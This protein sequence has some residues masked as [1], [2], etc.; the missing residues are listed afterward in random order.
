M[1]RAG[2]TALA[3]V[4]ALGVLAAMAWFDA[5]VLLQAEQR[6]RAAFDSGQAALPFS[7]G[8]FA[9]A[10]SVLL[11]AH[12]AW[13]SRSM[14]IGVIYLVVGAFFALLRWLPD[15]LASA[16]SYLY[17]TTVGPLNAVVVIGAGMAIAGVVVLAASFR[18][19]TRQP[20]LE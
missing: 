6:A 11:L 20:V 8:S 4:A 19:R 15:P 1:S 3:L 2:R 18:E 16:V 13:A 9:I 7:L 17:V 5:A 10:G 12:L 14:A